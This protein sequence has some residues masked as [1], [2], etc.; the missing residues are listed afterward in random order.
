MNHFLASLFASWGVIGILVF[1]A[2][3]YKAAHN[4]NTKQ[5]IFVLLLLGPLGWALL[6]IGLGLYLFNFV[7][8][9]LGD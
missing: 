1:T 4:W 7:F 8:D 3:D 9:K 2:L 6:I 5:T